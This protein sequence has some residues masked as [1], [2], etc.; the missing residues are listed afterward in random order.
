VN[1]TVTSLESRRAATRP[2]IPHPGASAAA[3]AAIYRG[4]VAHR[5]AGP[6]AREFTPKLFM[7]YVDVDAIPEA[8]DRL[9]LWSARRFAPVRF[10]RRDFFD[11][12]TRPL[13]DEVRDLVEQR[14]GRRPRGRITLLAHLRTFGWL[15]NPLAVYYCW[16]RDGTTLDA[17]VLEVTNTPW[18]ERQWYVFDARHG[19]TTAR[20]PKAMY[21][22]P[23]L[24][25]ELEYRISWSVPGPGLDLRIEV[26]RA[27]VPVFEADLELRR[28]PL[29]RRSAVA[30]LARYPLM[31]LRVSV[32]IYREA[33]RLALA[34]V[35][36]HR[37]PG[38]SRGD[39][40]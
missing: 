28:T 18:G 20:T 19:V 30:I 17:V 24:P 1:A 13:G 14:L 6:T 27:G 25:M 23:F 38:R 31:P 21:V 32:S 9:P 15:F 29:N 2:G 3:G 26:E 37:H 35:R 5:R 10:R 8:L 33:V 34:R 4:T 16:N 12:G 40:R 36:I 7:A 39:V 22:S 11:G